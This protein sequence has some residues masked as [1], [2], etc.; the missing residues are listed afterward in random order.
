MKL[1]EQD[2]TLNRKCEQLVTETDQA[3]E[4]HISKAIEEKYPHH[5]LF[6]GSTFAVLE[7]ATLIQTCVQHW[8]GNNSCSWK[9]SG[10]D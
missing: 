6:V 4:A 9:D 2:S 5:K 7:G 3:V 8:R 1:S 10:A